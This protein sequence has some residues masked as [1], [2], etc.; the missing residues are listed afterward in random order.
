MDL[1]KDDILESQHAFSLYKS[2]HVVVEEGSLS[3]PDFSLSGCDANFPLLEEGSREHGRSARE[4]R[5]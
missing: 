2:L 3:I 5:L 4:F 1:I